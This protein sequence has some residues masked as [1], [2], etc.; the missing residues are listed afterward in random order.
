M[1]YV[2]GL[3][4]IGCILLT[5]TIGLCSSVPVMAGTGTNRTWIK[6]LVWAASNGTDHDVF[7]STYQNNKWS[8]P[9]KISEDNFDNLHPCIDR[10]SHGVKWVVWTAAKQN[11]FDIHYVNSQENKWTAVRTI[12]SHLSMNIAPV[13][14]IDESDVP[15]VVWAANDSDS[16]DDIYFSRFIDGK[17]QGPEL[18]NRKNDVPDVLPVIDINDRGQCRVIWDG[19][20]NGM[21][22][23]LQSI[24]TGIAWSDEQIV[25]PDPIGSDAA[26][27]QVGLPDFIKEPDMLY[28]RVYHN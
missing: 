6:D 27:K 2:K 25:V 13:I 4:C 20:R 28:I 14:V 5:F 21:Y 26:G 15:W 3:S 1:D 17:W 7:Y 18:V 8:F 23:K 22:V 16:M 11:G 12:P 9:E 24:W 19:Y 10:D